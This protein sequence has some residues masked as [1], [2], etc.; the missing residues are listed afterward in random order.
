MQ[1]F[2]KNNWFK[3][4]ILIL[5]AVFIGIYGYSVYKSYQPKSLKEKIFQEIQKR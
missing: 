3:L 4:L 5:L 1:N 2:I